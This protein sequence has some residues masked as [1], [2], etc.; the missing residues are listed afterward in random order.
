MSDFN[1]DTKLYELRMGSYLNRVGI[2]HIT[3]DEFIDMCVES[4]K[5]ENGD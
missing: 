4:D 3:T 2:I 1:K 5:I